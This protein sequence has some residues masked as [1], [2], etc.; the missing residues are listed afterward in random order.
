LYDLPDLNQTIPY[1]HDQLVQWISYLVDLTGIDGIRVDT[2]PHVPKSFWADFNPAAG[3]FQFGEIYNEDP[4]FIAGYIPPFD[5][6]LSYPMFFTLRDIF[7]SNHSMNLIH[8]MILQYEANFQDRT[9]LGNFF[10]NHDQVRFLCC[11]SDVT[12]YKNAL[13]YTLLSEG[14]PIV[15]YGT[16]QG[17][18]GCADPKD[19][20]PLWL[21]GYNTQHEL[22]KFI[23]TIINYRK[24]NQLWNVD[25][26]ERAVDDT[27]YAFTRGDIF[28]AITNGGSNCSITRVINN[29][30]FPAGTTLCNLFDSQDCL[31]VSS[32]Q[33]PY[34]TVELTNGQAKVLLPTTTNTTTTSSSSAT[35]SSQQPWS[36]I[37]GG[38]VVFVPVFVSLFIVLQLILF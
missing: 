34:F 2:V 5:S 3:V 18:N 10:D 30:P 36:S 29:H 28:V 35:H 21:S 13:V 38:G 32:S 17:Y 20:E 37:S 19:R 12:L 4:A 11:N 33:S 1:V 24:T 23:E 26:V 8:D 9:V 6:I 14:I 15:Y 25:F 27:F 16:E 31:L 22:Y 7:C